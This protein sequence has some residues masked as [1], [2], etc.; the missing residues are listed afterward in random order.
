LLLWYCVL[1]HSYSCSHQSDGFCQCLC[2]F[3]LHIRA[4]HPLGI[5]CQPPPAG[6]ALKHQQLIPQSLRGPHPI[7]TRRWSKG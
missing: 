7:E 2:T 3:T 6:T 4:T 1:F 5:G